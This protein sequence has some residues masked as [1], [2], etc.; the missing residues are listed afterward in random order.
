MENIKPVYFLTN[1]F[2][3]KNLNKNIKRFKIAFTMLENPSVN[4]NKK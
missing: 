1:N 2:M 3:E 4:K